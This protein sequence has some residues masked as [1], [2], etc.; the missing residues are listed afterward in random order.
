MQR[1]GW[2][3]VMGFSGCMLICN[4]TNASELPDDPTK[5]PQLAKQTVLTKKVKQSKSRLQSIL[6]GRDRSVAVINGREMLVGDVQGGIK[7]ISID[8]DGVKISRDGA[9]RRL[10]LR[11][12]HKEI[13]H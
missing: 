13:V 3:R 11:S 8:E 9:V 4:L 7:L 2:S 5:T 6:H 12:I 10:S 1:T